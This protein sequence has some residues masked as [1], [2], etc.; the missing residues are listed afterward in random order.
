MNLQNKRFSNGVAT[1]KLIQEIV[2]IGGKITLKQPIIWLN[3]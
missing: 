3:P 1:L 2:K